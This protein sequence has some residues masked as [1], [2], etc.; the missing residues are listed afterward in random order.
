MKSKWFYNQESPYNQSYFSTQWRL[1]YL[2]YQWASFPRPADSVLIWLLRCDEYFH[3]CGAAAIQTCLQFLMKRRVT[4]CQIWAVRWEIKQFPSKFWKTLFGHPATEWLPPFS[5]AECRC[6]LYVH[7]CWIQVYTKV[8]P[9]WRK[10]R[11]GG[12]L[13]RRWLTPSVKKV[14]ENSSTNDECLNINGD[15]VKR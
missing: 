2:S 5:R 6:G 7:R 10:W 13:R 8:L 15:N 14:L 9:S 12:L 3:S 1:R 4:W 11:Y